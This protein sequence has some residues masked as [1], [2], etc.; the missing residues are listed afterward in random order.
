MKGVGECNKIASLVVLLQLNSAAEV[1]AQLAELDL[2]SIK[3][4]PSTTYQEEGQER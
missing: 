4:L 2:G 1:L 3:V